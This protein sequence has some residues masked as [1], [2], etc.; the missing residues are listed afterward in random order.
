MKK[1]LPF[2]L[3]TTPFNHLIYFF[4]LCSSF[5]FTS[6]HHDGNR[7]DIKN[8]SPYFTQFYTG[9]EAAVLRDINFNMSPDDVKKIET[10]KLYENTP[11]H[12]FY[13][14]SFATDSTAFS[15]YANVQYFFN[16]TNQLD[17]ITADIY[18]NDSTQQSAL[19]KTL[20]QYFDERYESA[21]DADTYSVWTGTF[22]DK[23]MNKKYEYTISL[24]KLEDDFGVSIE[25]YLQR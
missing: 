15:E 8:A 18:L 23:I 17:I 12:L 10:C 16:E 5:I 21:D 20:T 4:I 9:N 19:K 7:N 1:D 13:E 11:D 14:F 2:T 22:E 25:Y 24:K 3:Y 6:C